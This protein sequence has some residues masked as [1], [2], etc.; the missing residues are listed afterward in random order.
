MSTTYRATFGLAAL[1]AVLGA[2]LGWLLYLDIA[3]AFGIAVTGWNQGEVQLTTILIALILG[4]IL[5]AACGYMVDT[6]TPQ[7]KKERQE[8]NKRIAEQ[9]KADHPRMHWMQDHPWLMVLSFLSLWV[10]MYAYFYL[11]D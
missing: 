3:A 1:G 2:V 6:Q 8:R 9:F 7:A 10:L 5:G 11:T 4:L